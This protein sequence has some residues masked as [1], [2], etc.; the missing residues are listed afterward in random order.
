M[1]AV[2]AML[3]EVAGDD[4]AVGQR[5]RGQ[6]DPG[7]GAPE[8]VEADRVV[9]ER[10]RHLPRLGHLEREVRGVGERACVGE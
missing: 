1:R 5:L 6:R 2:P 10:A 9:V 4:V 7:S 8:V 3:A